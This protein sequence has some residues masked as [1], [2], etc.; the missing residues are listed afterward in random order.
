MPKDPADHPTSLDDPRGGG[1]VIQL[2]TV[3]A[4]AHG[5]Y[6]GLKTVG[7]MGEFGNFGLG[8]FEG[9]DGEL[10]LIEG[11]TYRFT[12]DGCLLATSP[13]DKVPFYTV[14]FCDDLPQTP[15]PEGIRFEAF[16]SWLDRGLPTLNAPYAVRIDGRF[17]TVRTRSLP[18]QH[19]PYPTMIEIRPHQ[20]EFE[21]QEISGQMIGFRFPDFLG[22]VNVPGYHLHFIDEARLAGGHVIDFEISAAKVLASQR[23]NFQLILPTESSAFCEFE[24]FGLS[25][26]DIA[27]I[28]G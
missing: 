16:C 10:I 26:A 20:P 23:P 12:A 18:R 19:K 13:R 27:A 1:T 24:D 8:T 21:Y 17:E 3:P 28:E 15:T 7:Q 2:S 5:L 25:R 22:T 6:E 9:L 11:K 14:T 4:L